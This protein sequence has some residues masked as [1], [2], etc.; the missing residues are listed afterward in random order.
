MRS[1]EP[2]RYWF[3]IKIPVLVDAQPP[4]VPGLLLAVSSSI[5]GN[6]FFFDPLPWMVVAA[7]VLLISV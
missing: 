1:K 2:T 6:G 4:H 5:T 3:G 7:A